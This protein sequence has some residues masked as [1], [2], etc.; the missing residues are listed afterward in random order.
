[1]IYFGLVL[2]SLTELFE[3]LIDLGAFY[4]SPTRL[5][6]LVLAFVAYLGYCGSYS[7]RFSLGKSAKNFA[8]AVLVLIFLTALSV[9]AS[10][11]L[12]YSA[13]RALNTT[14]IYLMPLVVYAY[15]SINSA[16]YPH[17]LLIQKT[18]KCI[19]Y[20]GLFVALFG[21]LQ[22]ATGIFQTYPQVRYIGPIPYTRINSLYGDGNFLSYFLLFPLWLCLVGN[23]ALTGIDSLVK[24]YWIAFAIFI[25]I[26]LSGSRGGLLMIAAAAGSHLAYKLTKGRRGWVMALELPF[27]LLLPFGLLAYT[28]FGFENILSHVN[29]L[30]T[31]NESGFSRVM[32]WYSGLRLY[33]DHPLLGVG[34][35][36]FIT[37]DKGNLLPVNYVQPWVA[38]RIS[39]LAGHSNI[40]EILVESG[41]LTLFAYLVVQIVVYMAL[42]NASTKF[43]DS[44]FAVYRTIVFSTMIGN[45]LI[46]YYFLFFMILIGV[47][48][49]AVDRARVL[50]VQNN[51]Q[52]FARRN[53]WGNA[54]GV[55]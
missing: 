32:S 48:L 38:Q 40:V 26:V 11:D 36:N 24:R 37:M 49:F 15:L 9:T 4:L 18:G 1:M 14:S 2:S 41:P 29:S 5:F 42:L 31:G 12:A 52:T 43:G 46:S 35:G 55:G 47:L 16:K 21:L 27:V 51:P 8:L 28:Y 13:K 20:S 19:V 53:V 17:D 22:E 7:Y 50:A 25:A 54:V 39:T 34:P 10:N 23:E 6:L 45:L 44:R 30:D 3:R 33:L